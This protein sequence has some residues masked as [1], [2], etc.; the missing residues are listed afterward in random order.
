MVLEALYRVISPA[1][2]FDGRS[3]GVMFVNSIAVVNSAVAEERKALAYFRQAG[4]VIELLD[5]DGQPVDAED[6]A[7]VPSADGETGNENPL[8]T[9]P[10]D[11]P[12]GPPPVPLVEAGLKPL[13]SPNA[14]KPE[15][16]QAAED[17]GWTY[18]EADALTKPALMER[19]QAGKGP[20]EDSTTEPDTE[21]KA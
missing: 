16:I 12:D 5:A 21:E 9:A 13:P 7:V 11:D 17:R 14:N 10:G 15:W 18:E 1:A 3:C 8:V 19:L 2:K 4:Y 20:D 6:V